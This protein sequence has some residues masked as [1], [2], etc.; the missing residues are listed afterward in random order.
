LKSMNERERHV[1]I[2]RRLKDN[3]TTLED[4]SQQYNICPERSL[5]RGQ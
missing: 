1:L 3:L 4:L 2:E 5:K